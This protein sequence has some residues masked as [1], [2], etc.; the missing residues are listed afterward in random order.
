MGHSEARNHVQREEICPAPSLEAPECRGCVFRARLIFLVMAAQ[1]PLLK[2][3]AK[4]F[5]VLIVAFNSG[6]AHAAPSIEITNVPA[7]GSFDNLGGRVLEASPAAYRVAV[8]IYV[9]DAGWY[10][11]PYC[12]PQLTIIQPDEV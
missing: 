9:P 8:F 6:K 11:K 1:E 5:F 4:H 2:N 3:L 12:D 7:Y 10:S